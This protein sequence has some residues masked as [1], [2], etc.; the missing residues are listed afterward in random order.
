MRG[1][2]AGGRLDGAKRQQRNNSGPPWQESCGNLGGG[3]WEISSRHKSHRDVVLQDWRSEFWYGD[4]R[5][6]GGQMT[7]YGSRIFWDG[8]G[9]R[10]GGRM[11]SCGR[12][13]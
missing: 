9:G 5:H 6:S 11:N 4:G 2:D 3:G 13:G 12:Y 7:L 1:L 8:D 10:P